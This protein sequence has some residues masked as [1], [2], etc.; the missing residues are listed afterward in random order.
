MWDDVVDVVGEK[1]LLGIFAHHKGRF[2]AY[3]VKFMKIHEIHEI[4]NLSISSIEDTYSVSEVVD[5]NIIFVT[6]IILVLLMAVTVFVVATID[7]GED[8]AGLYSKYK[9]VKSQ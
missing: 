6:A 4:Q 9:Q 2:F 1:N 5:R 7:Y 3:F 8:T